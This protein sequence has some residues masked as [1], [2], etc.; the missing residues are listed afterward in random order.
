MND[1]D[2][3]MDALDALI[4]EALRGEPYLSAPLSLHRGVEARLRIA[5]LLDREKTRFTCSMAAFL[6]VLAA[7][8][9]V[10]GLLLWFTNLSFLYSEGVSGGKGWLDYYATAWA[11]SWTSYQGA[12]SMAVS[13]IVTVGALL[14]ALVLQVHKLIWND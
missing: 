8:L 9:S 3:P 1:F 6:G 10:A 14:L 13:F 5:S 7:S 2:E 12:Y 11:M 4:D